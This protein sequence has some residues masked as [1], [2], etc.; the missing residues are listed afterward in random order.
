MFKKTP[1]PKNTVAKI[2]ALTAL[3]LGLFMFVSARIDVIALPW[4]AQII[5][6][7]LLT[8]SI[9][10]TTS[11]LLKRY[12]FIIESMSGAA[13][14]GEGAYDFIITEFRSNREIKVCH[15]SDKSI[16]Y[17]RVVT[18]ENKKAVSAERKKMQRYTYDITFAA[19]RKLEIVV[20]NGDELASMLVTYDEELLDA[21]ISIGVIKR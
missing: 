15:V 7:I 20:E 21:L 11:Y 19:P 1:V 10:V 9:H 16:N 8:F 6:I 12:T 3:V 18:P 2:S 14:S 5:A 13:E 17:I 4:L